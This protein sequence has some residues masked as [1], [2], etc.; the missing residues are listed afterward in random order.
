MTLALRDAGIDP[1]DVV[2]V[3]AHA[4]STPTGDVAEAAA[5]RAALGD[6]ALVSAPKSMLGHLLG[7]A[8]AVETIATVLSVRDGVVPVTRNLEDLDD[9]VEL[10]VVSVEPRRLPVPV[11]VNNAFGFG[12]HNVA[13]VVR[14]V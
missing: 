14:Q 5:I 6:H 8:G 2:S 11:A 1:A 4:T 12:G 10:D 9:G 3:N 13:L 7:A